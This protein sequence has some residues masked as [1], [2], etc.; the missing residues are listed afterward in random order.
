MTVSL[1][2]CLCVRLCV[3]VV[4][5]VVF[6]VATNLQQ[7]LKQKFCVLSNHQIK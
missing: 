5:G 1:L 7:K 4:V 6:V 2:H 3:V